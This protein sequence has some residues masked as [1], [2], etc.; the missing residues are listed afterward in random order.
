VLRLPNA[1]FVL[2]IRESTDWGRFDSAEEIG[3]GLGVTYA[4]LLIPQEV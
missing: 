2:L 1:D 3:N 4:G